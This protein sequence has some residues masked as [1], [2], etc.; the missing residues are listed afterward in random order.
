VRF[1]LRQM[2]ILPEEASAP[3]CQTC[4][5]P[6]GD[7]GVRTSWGFLA[8]TL[9]MPADK[10]WAEARTTILQALGVL[11]PKGK[12][13]PRLDLV[14]KYDMARLTYD[15]HLAE[16]VRMARVCNNCHALNFAGAELDK[17]EQMIRQADLLMSEAIKIVARLYEDGLLKKPKTYVYP[18][19]DFLALHDAPTAIEQ[20]LW[21]MFME[22]RMR[23][24]QGAF[25]TNPD[26]TF[27]YGWSQMQQDLVNIKDM[28]GEI[29]RRAPKRKR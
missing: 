4:H 26:F 29:R 22:H 11:D 17:G 9:P 24:F 5:M 2:G 3:S 6:Y 19:P 27:W 23:A 16:N 8:V 14:K 1:Q 13:T 20:K 12:P 10:V 15:D 18:F 28:A 25:H 21:I 7:H